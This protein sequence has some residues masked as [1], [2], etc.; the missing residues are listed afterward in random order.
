M[1]I[2]DVDSDSDS[3]EPTL[4][5]AK[6]GASIRIATM[7]RIESKVDDVKED[8]DAMKETMK[9]ILHL[10]DKAKIPMGLQRIIR[11]TFQ[12]KICLRIPIRPPVI[13]SMC[14]KAII[15]CER[16]VNGWYSGP[17]AL[18]KNCPA[19][20]TERGY[21]ETMLIRGLDNFLVEVKGIIQTDDEKDDDD[22]PNV[23]L[24]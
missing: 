23:N 24:S 4:K 13:M 8:I 12:C 16:C 22:L 15:G 9:D 6:D 14:C 19:C 17:E 20:R 11:D 18:T 3:D 10:N 21:S 2:L 1:V 5:R 7:S